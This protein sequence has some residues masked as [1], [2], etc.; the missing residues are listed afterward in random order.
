MAHRI[1]LQCGS[2]AG[3]K[4]DNQLKEVG[5]MKICSNCGVFDLGTGDDFRRRAEHF[6][7]TLMALGKTIQAPV[8]DEEARCRQAACLPPGGIW[9]AV[10]RMFSGREI[11]HEPITGM[12]LVWIPGG[13]FQMGSP[14]GEEGRGPDE[15]PQHEVCVDGFWLGKYEVTQGQWQKVMGSNPSIFKKGDNY[16]VEN[17]SWQ[18]A[19]AFI[20]KL[21]AMNGGQYTFRLPTEAEWEYACRAGTTTPFFFGET[22]GTDQANYDGNHTYGKG[23]KGV[24]RERTTPVGSFPANAFGLY[25]MHGNVLEWCKDIYSDKAYGK[26]QRSN[27]IYTGTDFRSGSDRV[28]RGGSCFNFPRHLRSASRIRGDAADRYYNV[29][30]RLVRLVS[31]CFFSFLAFAAGSRGAAPGRRNFRSMAAIQCPTEI[32]KPF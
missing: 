10:K 1:Q 20:K 11:G 19:Q 4:D 17:V 32:W 27:P 23:K 6:K 7:K 26:H 16:P 3:S 24:Y 13:C 18:D 29:G 12:E 8:D 5:V 9:R 14:K 21:T 25:D 28:L 15:G 2:E 22:I 30:F 31:I